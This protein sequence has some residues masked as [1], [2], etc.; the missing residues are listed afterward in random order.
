LYREKCPYCYAAFVDSRLK[1][2]IYAAA[3]SLTPLVLLMPVFRMVDFRGSGLLNIL[4]VFL[5]TPFAMW[6]ESR[7]ITLLL[8]TCRGRRD[9]FL[10][11][12]VPVGTAALATYVCNAFLFSAALPLLLRLI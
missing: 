2:W 10:I 3:F 7:S 1:P 5:Y 9:P 12:A 6:M 4:P 8:V 11:A